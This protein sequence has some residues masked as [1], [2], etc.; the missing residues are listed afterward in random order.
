L[1]LLGVNATE[2]WRSGRLWSNLDSLMSEDRGKRSPS[3]VNASRGKSEDAPGIADAPKKAWGEPLL[4]LDTAWTALENRLCVG[5]I[6]GEIAVLCVWVSLSGLSAF[7]APGSGNVS[8]LVYRSIVSAIVFGTIA[9]FVTRPRASD[10][11]PASEAYRK[12]DIVHQV[13]TTAA[14]LTGLLASRFWPNG[15]GEYASNLKS[16]IQNASVLML[17]GGL[18]GLVTRLTLWLALLGASIATSRGKHINI[19]VATRFL[20]KR[21]VAPVAILGWAAA[22]A[23]CFMATWGFIDGI[24]VTKFDAE[25]FTAC[26]KS[27][28]EGAGH[29]CDT[30]VADRLAKTKKGIASDLFLL[31]RQAS[32]D[33]RTF[34]RVVAGQAYEKWLLGLEWN[35]WMRGADWIQHFP[36]PGVESLIVPENLLDQA[37]MPAVSAPGASGA[38]GLLIRDLDFILPFGLLVIGIKFVVRILLVLSGHVRVDPDSAHGDDETKHLEEKRR[39][40]QTELAEA[41][42]EV[43]S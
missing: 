14:V 41:T 1:H 3:D 29:L 21:A 11:V 4:R 20:S 38:A 28:G 2:T 26:A 30:P 40:K 5:V 17:I 42:K 9:H 25:A 37:K 35:E 13:V 31:G 10:G 43:A 12:K 19:D 32:L 8:G 23:V 22:A 6:V 33:V 34:P 18:R 16:W 27:E 36:A 15:G 24:S 39:A 7:Y